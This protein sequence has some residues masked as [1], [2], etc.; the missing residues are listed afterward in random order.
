MIVRNEQIEAMREAAD[1]AFERKLIRQLS[2][3][4]P[5]RVSPA[6]PAALQ[7]FVRGA[8]ARGRRHGIT[9]QPGL[10]EFCALLL[11][12]VPSP[13]LGEPKWLR[14]VLTDPKLDESAKVQHM[15]TRAAKAPGGGAA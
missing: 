3:D 8:L 13:A 7:E 5:D 6:P 1:L 12:I 15:R 4:M 10:T 2:A 9:S 11:A 14:R